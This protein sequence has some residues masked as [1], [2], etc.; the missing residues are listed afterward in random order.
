M[1]NTT[2]THYISIQLPYLFSMSLQYLSV[3]PWL[4]QPS[5]TFSILAD[6]GFGHS[7]AINILLVALERSSSPP[8]RP[9]PLRPVSAPL[10]CTLT[11]PRPPRIFFL[12]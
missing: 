7:M 1:E 8:V 6:T 3:S 12:S 5:F 4:P 10:R 11:V 2:C 9:A